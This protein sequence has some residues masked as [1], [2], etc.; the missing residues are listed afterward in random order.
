MEYLVT[1]GW[2][3]LALFV[4]IAFLVST[5]AFSSSSF[6]ITEC[7]FQPDLPCSP[8]IIYRDEAIGKAVLRFGLTN[9]LGFPI[10][11]TNVT[12]RATDMGKA[13][14][15]VY[16]GSLPVPPGV[17]APGKSMNFNYT[18]LEN[19]RQ[20]QPRD[21][22]TVII[23]ITYQ[24]CKTGTCAGSYTTSGRLSSVVESLPASGPVREEPAEL[25]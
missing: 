8:Y 23:T 3:L 19:E 17:A 24:S 21:F 4:V 9:A 15:Y 1:Y 11:V 2:A 7:T 25:P 13:G 22:R 10:N 6:S 14:V 20:P 18:F 12:Y 16:T 5:G